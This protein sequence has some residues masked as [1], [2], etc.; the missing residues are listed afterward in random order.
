MPHLILRITRGGFPLEERVLDVG[1]ITIGRQSGNDLCIDDSRLSRHHAVITIRRDGRGTLHDLGSKNA[2]MHGGRR[3]TR[4]ALSPGTVFAMGDCKFEVLAENAAI[5]S[6]EPDLPTETMDGGE[7][8]LTPPE[9]FVGRSRASRDLLALVRRIA[10]VRGSVL[11]EGES[12][13]GKGVVARLLHD[14]DPSATGR[15]V[16]VNCAAIAGDLIESELFGHRR[17]AFTGAVDDRVG[18]FSA[19]HEGTLFL[20]EIGDMS[21]S[22]QAKILRAIEEEEIEPLGSDRPVPISV[23]V[24]AATNKDLEAEREAGTFRSDLYYR[25]AAVKLRVPPL[26]ERPEDVMLLVHHFLSELTAQRDDEGPTLST[27]TMSALASYPWPGN[28]RELR[29]AVLHASIACEDGVIEPAHLPLPE[30]YTSKPDGEERSPLE[31][32]EARQVSVALEQHGWNLTRTAAALGIT[33]KTLRKRI[34]DH[35]LV[36]PDGDATDSSDDS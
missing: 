10:V 7:E 32:A 28:V 16:A 33:R 20:D 13:S 27:A 30:Q 5:G 26:R 34:R 29:N 18:K 2:F 14:L 11:I 4:L 1:T 15:F 19:A 17:G 24:I 21:Q 9:G 31:L 25:L 36:R 8:V 22:A 3:L 12:G 35:G 6:D 23:R